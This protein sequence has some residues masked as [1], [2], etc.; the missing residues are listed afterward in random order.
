MEMS[1]TRGDFDIAK[2]LLQVPPF[3]GTVLLQLYMH[4][5]QDVNIN[6]YTDQKKV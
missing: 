1:S 3:H 6:T 4:W 2:N 5:R